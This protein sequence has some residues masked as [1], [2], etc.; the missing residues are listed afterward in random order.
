MTDRREPPSTV[1]SLEDRIRNLAKEDDGS[2]DLNVRTNRRKLAIANTIVGQLMP[3]GLV[4][5][6]SAMQLRLGTSGSR[7][8]RDLDAARARGMT[9]DD[10][11]DDLQDRLEDGWEDFTGQ[12]IEDDGP[13]PADVPDDYIMR[14]FTIRLLYRRSWWM[15]VALELGHDEID[16]TLDPEL[17]VSF[18]AAEVFARIGL[19]EPEPV[20][21]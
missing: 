9:V 18:E 16:S 17:V 7:F 6:G 1:R 20:R 10:F 13:T 19:P 21:V 3:D 15:N 12:L 8:T 11:V 2:T 4:K 5:G 14:P